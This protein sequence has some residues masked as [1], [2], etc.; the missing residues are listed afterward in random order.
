MKQFILLISLLALFIPRVQAYEIDSTYQKP[1]WYKNQ[2]MKGVYMAAP[3]IGGSL[4]YRQFKG[5]YRSLR[6]DM[7]INA[8]TSWDNYTQFAPLA[9]CYIMKVSGVKSQS[10][11]GRMM[12]SHAFSAAIMAG[13]VNGL[14]YPIGELRP[15]G[16]TRNSYPSGHTAT[17]FFAASMLHHEYGHIS[18]WISFGSY[19][20]ATATG[21]GRVIHNRH[22]ISDVMAGAG[23]GLLSGELGYYLADVIFGNKYITRYKPEPRLPR[24]H[25]PSYLALRVGVIMP[26]SKINYYETENNLSYDYD[27]KFLSGSDASVDGAWF[28]NPYFGIGGSMHIISANLALR[29]NSV[30]DELGEEVGS[31]D[32]GYVATNCNLHM[33]KSTLNLHASYP[34]T[35]WLRLQATLS[36]GISNS[37]LRSDK[38]RPSY[39]LNRKYSDDENAFMEE[40]KKEIG[41]EEFNKLM[42]DPDFDNIDEF[43]NGFTM[44]AGASLHF[45]LTRRFDASLYCDWNM[46]GKHAL[47]DSGKKLHY[48]SAGFST[49]LKF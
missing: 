42:N 3:L 16:S 34:F 1:V 21:I 28:A 15:D 43:T 45:T 40:I 9:A 25:N 17:A 20:M 22:W 41:E 10:Q 24:L 37:V 46:V 36:A 4:I 2:A 8:L 47:S 12:V 44:G 6:T 7:K 13:L 30:K 11:W 14:K 27:V 18:P 5:D 33:I 32:N 29:Q 48:I 49:A 39:M 19:A 35:D 23:I 38:D 31:I 26:V